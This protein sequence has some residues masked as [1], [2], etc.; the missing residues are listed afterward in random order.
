MCES[1]ACT[2]ICRVFPTWISLWPRCFARVH[3]VRSR[4]GGTF[5][6]TYTHTYCSGCRSPHWYR[7]NAYVCIFSWALLTLHT[8]RHTHTRTQNNKQRERHRT[9]CTTLRCAPRICATGGRCR[10]VAMFGAVARARSRTGVGIVVSISQWWCACVCVHMCVSVLQERPP[11]MELASHR[12][13]M[14]HECN[15][16]AATP[17]TRSA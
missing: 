2:C 7:Y 15:D 11:G 16:G 10:W 13:R 5:T 14:R 4:F 17:S 3:P 1:R 9:L 12:F 8:D 6:H